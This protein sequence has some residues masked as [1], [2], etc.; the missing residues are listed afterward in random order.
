MK[1]VL[2]IDSGSGGLNILASCIKAGVGGN[3]LYYSDKKNLPYGSKTKRQLQKILSNIL[4]EVSAFFHFEVVLLACNTLT[5]STIEY[6]RKKYK[7]ILFVGT[8]PATKPAFEKFKKEDVLLMATERTFENLHEEGLCVPL[9]PSLIDENLLELD[10]LREYL[11][12][13]LSKYNYKKAVVLGC[14]HYLAVKNIVQEILPNAE[15]FDSAEGVTK[16]MVIVCGEGNYKVQFISSMGDNA[17]ISIYFRNLI[18][19]C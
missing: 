2:V 6:A 9:L 14:T 16:R 7:N 15:I 10:K 3:F 18:Q 12:K 8:V 4:E 17:V 13:Y 1:K 5:T 19:N 11:K